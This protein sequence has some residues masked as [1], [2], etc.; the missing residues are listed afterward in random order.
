MSISAIFPYI[1]LIIY[2]I[3]IYIC[4]RERERERERITH[5]QN[6]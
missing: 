5:A 2:Y 1:S 4:V 6:F 3:Y